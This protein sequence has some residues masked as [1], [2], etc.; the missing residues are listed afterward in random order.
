M[1]QSRLDVA[2]VGARCAGAP[3]AQRLAAAGARVALLDAAPLPSPQPVSTHLAQ[4][5]GMDELDALGVGDEVRRLSPALEASGWP[6]MATARGSPTA[7]AGR[8]TASAG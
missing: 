8:R 1:G 4:P 6:T 3:L 5:R 7:P 2:V